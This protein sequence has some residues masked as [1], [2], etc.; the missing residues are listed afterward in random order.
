[1]IAGSLPPILLMATVAVAS[2][3]PS[4]LAA[5][6]GVRDVVVAGD[7]VT[8]RE[9]VGPAAAGSGWEDDLDRLA[10]AGLLPGEQRLL[11]LAE[12]A[13]LLGEMGIGAAA[14]GWLPARP[15]RVT[16]ASQTVSSAR[17]AAAGEAAVRREL[18]LAPG[19]E[20]AVVAVAPPRPLLAP[21]GKLDLETVAR[22]P[23]L[24]G[25]LWS[26]EVTGRVNGEAALAC[27]VRYRVTVTGD[28]LVTTRAVR[29]HDAIGPQH[30]ALER[31]E[32]SELR[33]EPIRSVEE[34]D[35]RRAAR[36]VPAGTALT[37][38]WVEPEPLVRRGELVEVVARVGPVM[39]VS[40]VVALADGGA[41]EAVAVRTADRREFVA[42]VTGPGRGEVNPE[43]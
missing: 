30:V 25:G 16:R 21:L 6:A 19:D 11:S 34:L 24:R 10:L 37:S 2:S 32:V 38:E 7:S 13:L 1:M 18:R 5:A 17:L 23:A 42:R 22:P 31:R 28:V 3:V 29:R 8:V 27:M 26:V 33:G 14:R 12:I 35:G 39:V 4:G 36:A 40:R 20:A 41:G 15:V 43:L 9:L